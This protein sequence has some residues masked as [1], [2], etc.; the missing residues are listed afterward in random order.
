MDQE[1]IN[2]KHLD[3]MATSW[4][5]R[6]VDPAMMT[7]DEYMKL[8]DPDEKYHPDS[9]YQTK[10]GSYDY[11]KK[12]DFKTVNQKRIRG[13]MFEFCINRRRITYAKKHPDWNNGGTEP[14]LRDA[15]GQIAN[16]THEESDQQGMKPN[17]YTIGV[18][19]PEEGDN[20]IAATQDEW[21]CMLVSVAEEYKGFGLAPLLVKMA[22]TLEPDKP[23]G[24]FTTGGRSNFIK[25]HREFVRQAVLDG[26]YTR[27]V[28]EGVITTQRAR[29]IIQSAKITIRPQQKS[30]IS[31]ND[32]KNWV[33]YA[34]G[35]DIHHL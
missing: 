8:V 14:W 9:A 15:D 35:W 22:R 18:W 21:G 6:N 10:V 11:F 27:A 26:R 3:L 20:C 25:V 16:W 33:C 4:N 17:E 5:P 32:P 24:G 31:S 34:D 12:K 30:D 13:I 28:K 23:S 7:T 29:E 19:T 1:I 2:E